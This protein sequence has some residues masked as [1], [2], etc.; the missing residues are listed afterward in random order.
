[1]GELLGSGWCG[2]EDLGEGDKAGDLEFFSTE[3]LLGGKLCMCVF[4]CWEQGHTEG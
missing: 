3:G 2:G 1:M 4:L